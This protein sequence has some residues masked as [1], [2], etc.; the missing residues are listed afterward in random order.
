MKTPYDNKEKFKG[1][2]QQNRSGDEK[3]ITS[4]DRRPRVVVLGAGFGGLWAARTL[5]D[6]PVN[7]S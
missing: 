2:W 1:D 4:Q 5:A 3:G 6:G 7:V